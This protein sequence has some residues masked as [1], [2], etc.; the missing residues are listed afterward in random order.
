MRGALFHA[1]EAAGYCLVKIGSPEAKR[2]VLPLVSGRTEDEDFDLKG[3]ALECNWPGMT[4][5]ELL[6]Q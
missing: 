4:V 5:P 2:M 3:L 6:G 1:R